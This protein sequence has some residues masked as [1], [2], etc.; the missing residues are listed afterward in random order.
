MAR[1]KVAELV[2][3]LASERASSIHGAEYIMANSA[4][5]PSVKPRNIPV[6]PLTDF[7]PPRIAEQGIYVG[8]RGPQRE[9]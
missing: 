4:I 8:L 9:V 1:G 6:Y 3:F 2:A 7:V 5:L